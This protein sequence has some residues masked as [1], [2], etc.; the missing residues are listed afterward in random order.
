MGQWLDALRRANTQKPLSAHPTEPTEGASV[1]FVGAPGRSMA[2]LKQVEPGDCP[3][4]DLLSRHPVVR[5]RSR[6]L[7]EVVVWVADNAEAPEDT[8]EIVYTETELRLVAG[9]PPAESRTGHGRWSRGPC[10]VPS[11]W[12][13]GCP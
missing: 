2:G 6:L 11:R 5:V 4:S 12:P 8:G 10:R 3:L 13:A 9:R 7:G 1:G